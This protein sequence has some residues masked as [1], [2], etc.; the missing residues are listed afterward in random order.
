MW[1]FNSLKNHKLLAAHRSKSAQMGNISKK[2]IQMKL[3]NKPYLTLMGLFQEDFTVT[4]IFSALKV[5]C[6]KNFVLFMFTLLFKQVSKNL[7]DSKKERKGN[8]F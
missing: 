3:R 4:N 5:D 7:R 1:Q 2:I 8:Y 6:L